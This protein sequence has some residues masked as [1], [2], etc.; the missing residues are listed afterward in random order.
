MKK[1][2]N[3]DIAQLLKEWSAD[4][5][6]FVP[7]RKEGM[8]EW[9]QWDGENTGFLDWYR[10]TTVP[11]KALFLPP[12][13]ALFRFQKNKDGYEL[14]PSTTDEKR[15]LIF[16]IRPCDARALALLDRVFKDS[17][18]DPY[19]LSRRQGSILVGLAC[20]NP[21]ETCFCTSLGLGPAESGDVD[22]MLTD[23][24]DTFLI[25][26]VTD[27]GRELLAKTSLTQD[28]TDADEEKA[29]ELRGVAQ[30]RVTRIVD[31]KD[32]GER[33]RAIFEDRDFWEQVAAKCLSC[34]VCTLLCPTCYC[35]DM[36]DEMVSRSGTRF[37]GWD[38]CAFPVYTNM[39]AENPR[40]EKW[41]RVRQRVAHK[42]E[43]YPM[44]FGLLACT[45]CGRC[46]R[47]CPVNWDITRILASLTREKR[48]E[49]RA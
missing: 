41:R 18:E 46:V 20:S 1:I 2:A 8:A 26:A 39:P 12:H 11:P 49:N 35:F 17:Y 42:Y 24:G 34:G 33:L 22:L 48:V 43:F 45:G 3:G 30:S 37:R 10:N 19:Y 14:A 21:Y 28:A 31:T 44:S 25:D 36:C 38:S 23:I 7:S 6:V 15:R 47:L 5:S 29:R 40:E 16:G 32:I 4:F 27:K 13:E 9:T